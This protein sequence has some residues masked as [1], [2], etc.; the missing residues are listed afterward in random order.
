ML[1]EVLGKASILQ[2]FNVTSTRGK[3]EA[4][5]FGSRIVDGVLD[6]KSKY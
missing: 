2:T 4:V 6:T 3:K 5:V 1:K